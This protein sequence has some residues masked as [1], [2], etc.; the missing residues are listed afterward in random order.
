MKILDLVKTQYDREAR[1]APALTVL[2]PPV[3]LALVW[4][5]AARTPAVGLLTL[6]IAFGILVF[7][8]RPIPANPRAAATKAPSTR[9]RGK[10][11]VK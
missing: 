2:L 8:T 6:L 11:A 1:F 9:S 7:L 3:L 10:G 4:F 5:P